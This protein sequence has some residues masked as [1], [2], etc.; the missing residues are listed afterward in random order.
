MLPTPHSLSDPVSPPALKVTHTVMIWEREW[1]TAQQDHD[2]HKTEHLHESHT[3]Q[4]IETA[5]KG[6]KTGILP[7]SV[8][9]WLRWF[10]PFVRAKMSSPYSL[11]LF[12]HFSPI[13]CSSFV[14]FWTQVPPNCQVTLWFSPTHPYFPP[15]SISIYIPLSL[16]P[17]LSTPSVYFQKQLEGTPFSSLF[18]SLS[19]YGANEL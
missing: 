16:S 13:L 10:Y 11:W 1:V 7:R 18:P 3:S 2:W 9:W 15:L 17:C 8:H 5:V 6:L 12:L 14:V 19:Q 4:A